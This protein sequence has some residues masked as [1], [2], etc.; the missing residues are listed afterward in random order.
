MIRYERFAAATVIALAV[1]APAFA[2]RDPAQVLMPSEERSRAFFEQWGFSQAVIHGDTVYLSGVVGALAPG[3]TDPAAAY[4]RAFA[5]IGRVLER[6]GSS[7]DDVLEMTTYHTD[8]PTQIAGFRAVKDRYVKAP[9][10]A[11]TAIDID[12]L[13][14]DRGLVEIKVV[15]KVA[16]AAPR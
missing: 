16:P 6:A 12:R 15:A 13:V 9:F 4:D 5:A 8:L 7:W 11:W 2:K 1:A 3:E 14:P 10:P